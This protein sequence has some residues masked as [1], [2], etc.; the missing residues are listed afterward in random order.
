MVLDLG[1]HSIDYITWIDIQD[2]LASEEL[3]KDKEHNDRELTLLYIVVAQAS[4]C[5]S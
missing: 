1:L 5:L 2:G 4:S 3:H